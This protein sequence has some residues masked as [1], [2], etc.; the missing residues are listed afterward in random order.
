M[1]DV[2][3]LDTETFPFRA[4]EPY[5]SS[6]GKSGKGRHAGNCFVQSKR[7]RLRKGGFGW[8]EFEKCVVHVHGLDE[9]LELSTHELKH[10]ILNILCI[11]TRLF[12]LYP[13]CE[14]MARTHLLDGNG[15]DSPSGPCMSHPVLHWTT[16]SAAAFVSCCKRCARSHRTLPV[17]IAPK[18]SRP[19]LLRTCTV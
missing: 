2:V 13:L 18:M 5:R 1:R 3:L 12:V 11:A 14:W 16:R 15:S 10:M 9:V 7:W 8:S 19:N 6:N 17:W 4:L